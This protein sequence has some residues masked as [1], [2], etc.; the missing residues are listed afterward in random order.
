MKCQYCGKEFKNLNGL[1]N[2]EIRCKVN[3][4]HIKITP[5]KGMLGK[6]AWNKGLNKTDERV[7]KGIITHR[8]RYLEGKYDYSHNKHSEETKEKIRK[9]KLELCKKQGTNLCGKGLRG[10]YKGFYC[11]SS[12]ELAY[13]I[14]CL[15]HNIYLKRNK[16]RFSYILDGVERSYFPDFLLEGETYIEIKGYYDRKTKE[17]E[18]QFPKDKKLIILKEKE[19]KPILEY[20]ISKYGKKFYFLYDK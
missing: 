18:K 5:S 9:Q 3:P 8:K 14:Y 10:Y 11:Q 19:M 15:D 20:V 12:W 4:N 16:N 7:L 6:T 1:H 13:V 17:K 2:H